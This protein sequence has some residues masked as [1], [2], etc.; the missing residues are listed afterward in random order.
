[1]DIIVVA[2]LQ[3]LK[4]SSSSKSTHLY[5]WLLGTGV[6]RGSKVLA[7]TAKSGLTSCHIHISFIPGTVY[8]YFPN[9]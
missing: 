9:I 8:M 1:M 3:S 2:E 5:S 6:S 7:V 4:Y